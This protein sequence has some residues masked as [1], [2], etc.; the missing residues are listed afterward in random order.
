YPGSIM[1]GM[2]DQSDDWIASVLS[3]IRLSLD[4]KATIVSPKEVAEIR[5]GS[6]DQKQSY[7]YPELRASTPQLMVPT[8]A[9]KITASHNAP[10][11]VGGK[12]SPASAFNFE[13][14]STG[15]M[16]QKGM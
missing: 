5:N 16:Q 2:G 3:Y 4:N 7:K 9:W 13:G 1:I 15:V 6:S 10:T 14:W 12:T 11:R 8:E